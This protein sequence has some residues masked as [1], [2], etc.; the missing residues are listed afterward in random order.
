VTAIAAIIR[1]GR[2][3]LGADTA[4]TTGWDL[5]L[6]PDGKVFTTGPYV[7]GCAGKV[8]GAQLLQY[9]LDPPAP[10][11]DL[12]RFMATTFV[13]AVRTCLKDGG[14]AKRE[15]EQENGDTLLLAGVHGRLFRMWGDY[16]VLECAQ[17][18]AAAGCGE[19]MVLGALY[20][21]RDAQTGVRRRLT[22]ALKA[23][24]CFNA[25]VRGPFTFAS[26]PKRPS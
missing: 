9:A 3:H 14:H 4:V 2:V 6:R 23:A 22:V 7:F 13:D 15:N 12:P 8:R 16:S 20:A 10:T 21:T 1:G 11:V 19:D 17:P 5:A 26:T 18:Y 25:A 24:E